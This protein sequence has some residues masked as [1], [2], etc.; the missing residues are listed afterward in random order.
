MAKIFITHSA[1]DLQAYYVTAL[2]A[3]RP[4]GDIIVNP[5]GRNLTTGELIEEAKDCQVIVSHRAT[6]GPA[7]VFQKSPN[8]VAFLRCAVDIRDVDVDAASSVGILVANAGPA[9]VEAT[10]EIALALMLDVSRDLTESTI[11]YRQGRMPPQNMGRQLSG[12]SAGLIGYGRIG[13]H[14]AAILVAMGMRVLVCDPYQTVCG[15]GLEQVDMETLL[16][17]A[18]YVLPLAQATEETENLMNAKTFSLMKQGS[19]FVNVS[20]GNLVNEEALAAAFKEG[21]I[22]RIAMDVGRAADQRPSPRLASLPGVVATPHLGG[23]TGPAAWTQAMS[24]VEQ[25]A[26]IVRGR[27][28]PRAINPEHATRLSRLK[29]A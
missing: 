26:E 9:F 25:T 19:V 20:R 12:S 18:D 11:D 17:Q 3:I 23:L 27:V 14:L 15:P 5:T 13:R 16:G 8:L 21:R 1:E 6:H 22:A 2:E 10:A 24:S 29:K 28:P 4:Y 7:E